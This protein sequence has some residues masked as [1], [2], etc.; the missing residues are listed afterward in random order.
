MLPG[1]LCANFGDSVRHGSADPFVKGKR[2]SLQKEKPKN[3]TDEDMNMTMNFNEAKLKQLDGAT[4]YRV[5][6]HELK[7]DRDT[8]KAG[9]RARRRYR[10]FQPCLCVWD[11]PQNPCRCDD[12][13]LWWLPADAIIGEDKAGRKD[14]HGKELQF[15]DVRIDSKI[16]VETVRPV[17]AGALKGL[18]QN[19]SPQTVLLTGLLLDA[20]GKSRPLTQKEKNWLMDF[21]EA[22]GDV[23][24]SLLEDL[25]APLRFPGWPPEPPFIPP[26]R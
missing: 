25:F 13:M 23:V 20:G 22:G 11:S 19:I 4:T 8:A 24:G 10:L 16:L 9:A 7:F 1:P 17:S 18:G 3:N 21:L 15:F 14:H 12:G 5:Y 6:G 2:S 26:P